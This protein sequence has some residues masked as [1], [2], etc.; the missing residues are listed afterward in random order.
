MKKVIVTITT[1]LLFFLSVGFCQIITADQGA[2]PGG[3]TIQ[4]N[5]FK[6]YTTFPGDVQL[7]LV[8]SSIPSQYLSVENS[9]Y[10]PVDNETQY[11]FRSL[12]YP[13]MYWEHLDLEWFIF[14]D[15][16]T[17]GLYIVKIN[18]TQIN[19]PSDP[20]LLL[21]DNMTMLQNQ[22]QRSLNENHTC[23]VE[24]T[25]ALDQL[26]LL[27]KNTLSLLNQTSL[28]NYN[29][30][31]E[32]ENMTNELKSKTR[33]INDSVLKIMGL[34]TNLTNYKRF[35]DSMTSFN[36]EF[37]YNIAGE[38]EQYHTVYYYENTIENLQ[39]QLG[40]VPMFIFFAILIT[41]FLT[42]LI[43]YKKWGSKKLTKTAEEI[44]HGITKEASKR[45]RFYKNLAK[46]P[47]KTT[48]PGEE[49]MMTQKSVVVE[50]EKT[51][52]ANDE[53]Q[54]PE[55]IEKVNQRIDNIEQKID[56]NYQHM[57]KQLDQLFKQKE[58]AST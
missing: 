19:V 17:Y 31:S 5:S 23:L 28:K 53:K 26:R 52:T 25:E 43:C 38:D 41:L 37:Y 16:H 58:K 49:T 35:F 7:D 13:V 1:I 29:I 14:Q 45:N 30:T 9:G 50:T 46:S 4:Y 47:L 15:Q 8:Y 44:H 3:K 27:Q 10:N 48:T 22:T 20:W 57:S 18:M 32:L 11:S 24:K 21:Y 33:D 56:L 55:E 51:K 36:N 6:E 40:G 34:Q 54:A 42:V 12:E 2:L 39:N